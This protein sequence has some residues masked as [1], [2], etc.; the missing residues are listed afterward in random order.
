MAITP[1]R[2]GRVRIPRDKGNDYT[3]DLATKRR[4]FVRQNTGGTLSH[5]LDRVRC[6]TCGSTSRPE[7]QPART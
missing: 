1:A 6:A 2:A 7:M 3:G 5:V 4:D